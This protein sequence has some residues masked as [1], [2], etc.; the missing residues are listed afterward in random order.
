MQTRID[1]RLI[2][3]MRD[4]QYANLK[5]QILDIVDGIEPEISIGVDGRPNRY[6]FEV[7][8]LLIDYEIDDKS[9]MARVNRVIL[10]R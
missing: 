9:T 3:L 10:V 8:G 5:A 7:D 6:R 2:T 1:I 4:P